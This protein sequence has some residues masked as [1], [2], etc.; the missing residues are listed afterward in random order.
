VTDAEY[1]GR[2]EFIEIVEQKGDDPW[3]DRWSVDGRPLESGKLAWY[4]ARLIRCPWCAGFWVSGLVAVAWCAYAGEW[5][6]LPLVWL[7]LSAAVGLTA[8]WLDP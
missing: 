6:G 2:I 4:I 7:G 1:A 8:K 5:V 3:D